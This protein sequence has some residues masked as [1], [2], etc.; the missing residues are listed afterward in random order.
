[1]SNSARVTSGTFSLASRLFSARSRQWA[2]APL[3]LTFASAIASISVACAREAPTRNVDPTSSYAVSGR[4]GK[5]Q[6][7]PP[8]ASRSR[9]T[10]FG[11]APT[12]EASSPGTSSASPRAS[13]Q[14]G[15]GC[16]DEELR[17]HA[18]QSQSGLATFYHDSL[19]G[20]RTASGER[21]DPERLSAA[22]RTLPFGTRLRVTR[23]DGATSAVLCVTINDRGPFGGRRR[24]LDVSRRAAERLDMI[25]A[26]VVR[27]RIDVL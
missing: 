19:T 4:R 25:R 9:V 10:T 13:A 24:I 20:N 2:F 15:T 1:M 22:H 17:Q 12:S 14:R 23:A 26:G 27:V 21:Y 16:S 11:S 6:L 7:A 3:A 8:N 18:R 5:A